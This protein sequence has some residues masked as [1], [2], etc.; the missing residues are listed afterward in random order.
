MRIHVRLGGDLKRYGAGGVRTLDS[1][2]PLTIAETMT[3]I[4]VEE[5]AEEVLVIVNDE[6]VPPGERDSRVLEDEDQLALMPQLKG[7]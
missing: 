4:G 6:V 1:A 5:A 7:G 3:R 2:E